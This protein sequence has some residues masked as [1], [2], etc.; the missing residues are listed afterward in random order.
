MPVTLISTTQ[1]I[2]RMTLIRILVL[3]TFGSTVVAKTKTQ[4]E[5]LEHITKNKKKEFLKYTIRTPFRIIMPEITTA[6]LC[7][8]CNCYLPV[9][10]RATGTGYFS[11][12]YCK[13]EIKDTFVKRSNHS[14]RCDKLKEVKKRFERCMCNIQNE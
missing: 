2:K 10:T 14:I 13:G 7:E 6:F 11:C 3:A 4:R 1:R 12:I 8:R 9:Y 5:V